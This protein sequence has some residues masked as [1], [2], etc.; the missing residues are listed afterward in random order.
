MTIDKEVFIKQ[1]GTF[2]LALQ[3]MNTAFEDPNT[4]VEV[5][6]LFVKRMTGL[7]IL[8]SKFTF[9]E[10]EYIAENFNDRLKEEPDNK[11]IQSIVKKAMEAVGW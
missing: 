1:F 11:I 7:G 2:W 3:E 10:L 8:R 6:E 9:E 5:F 4:G